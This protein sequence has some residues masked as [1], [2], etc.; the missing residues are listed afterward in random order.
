VQPTN[1]QAPLGLD[2]IENGPNTISGADA[3]MLGQLGFSGLDWLRINISRDFIKV[4][5]RIICYSCT[6]KL[7]SLGG[8]KN[9]ANLRIRLLMLLLFSGDTLDLVCIALHCTSLHCIVLV[10]C[11]VLLCTLV[12]A[13]TNVK[14]AVA[15]C[16]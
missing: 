11:F 6:L 1:I 4:Y 5:S 2:Y 8:A 9:R 12:V 13:D 15:Y 3:R 7:V 10:Q 16:K 14:G